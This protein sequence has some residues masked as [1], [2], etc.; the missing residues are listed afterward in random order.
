MRTISH[1][2]TKQ[3]WSVQADDSVA[4]ARL[5][6]AERQIRHLPVLDGGKLLGMVTERDLHT[7][8]EAATVE[9]IMTS[10]LEIDVNTPF[11]DALEQME[12]AGRD[13]IVI[14]R[15]GVVDGIFTAMDAVRVLREKLRSRQRK[16]EAAHVGRRW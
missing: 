5:M 11:P 4:V 12:H 13:A 6:L 1:Y 3:P 15:N 7:H 9:Q 8:G 16:P 14:T 2:M 10:A